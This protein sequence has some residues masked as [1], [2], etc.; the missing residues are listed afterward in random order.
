MA[1]KSAQGEK[2]RDQ[3]DLP[4][5][6]A[7]KEWLRSMMLIRRFEERA[8]EMYAKAKI[9]GV[10][11]LAIGEEATIVGAT[12][13]MRDN[14]YLLSTYREHG[15][16]LARGTSAE[17][18]MAELFGRVDGVSKGRGGSMHMF[19]FERRFMGGYGIVGGNLPIATG[20]ALAADYTE[21]E[22][23]VLCQFG[24]G[25]AN[26]GT[27]GEALNL[28]ALWK[29]PVVF[30]VTNNQFGMGTSLERHSAVTDL[31][32]RGDGFG[33]PG[34]RCDGMDVLDTH[35]VAS[36]A[37]K[38]AREDRQPR[39]AS[40]GRGRGR[41]ASRCSSRRSRTASAAT[42]WPTPRS[43]GPR[44]RSR[45]GASGTRSRASAS[46][47]W[48]RRCSPRTTSRS[49]T[50][51]RSRRSTRRSSSPT[52][53]RIPTPSRST[54]TSTCWATRSAAGTPSTSARPACTAARTSA[55]CRRTARA[56]SRS[57][58][59]SRARAATSATRAA[60]P[61]TRPRTPA[62]R[63]RRPRRPRT[64][65]RPTTSS[66]PKRRRPEARGE[67]AGRRAEEVL[68]RQRR[69]QRR[70]D[71]D[72]ALPRSAQR[73][74]AR[75]DVARRV[76]LP[77]GRG[78]RRL[79]RRV[80]GHAGAARGVRREA[81]ARH[82]DLREHDRRRGRRRRHGR[83]APRRGAHDGQLLA[84]GDGP[85]RQLGRAHP[86]HVRRPG[87]GAARRPHATGRGPPARADSLALLRIALPARA[88][89]ARRRPR[90]ARGRQGVAQG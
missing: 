49:S 86:L 82:A 22:D 25:A 24:D 1:V 65:N 78:H 76:R 61:P 57:R 47:S 85:D 21:T 2:E 48:T 26:Q 7:A 28:A 16:A 15:Q 74:A 31:H 89:A 81:R 23:A 29:L 55:R 5:P 73:G 66:R 10:L 30:M 77:H 50:S 62:R 18:G 64:R 43:T 52:S 19:D 11:H 17:A 53:R 70:R 8:G 88:G 33:V 27:F 87:L 69:R 72:D 34:M 40:P 12:R 36:E 42:R 13:A 44:S 75:G 41:P 45:S 3:R 9:G 84:A 90:D 32:K 35:A 38:K 46:A 4:D 68:R 79:Q 51:R 71:E 83:P 37:L 54:T 20:L 58:R 6:D 60:A 56:A 14:D 80:Q 39:R 63:T 59:S 67:H